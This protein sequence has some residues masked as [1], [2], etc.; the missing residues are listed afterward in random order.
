MFLIVRV[1]GIGNIKHG[2]C[3]LDVN[4]AGIAFALEA[5]YEYEY[6]VLLKL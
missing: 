1:V 6:C 5:M 3:R 4:Q 2:G